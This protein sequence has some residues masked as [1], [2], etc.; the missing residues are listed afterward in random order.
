MDQ[1]LPRPKIYLRFIVIKY[2]INVQNLKY[3]T[4]FAEN[5]KEYI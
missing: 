3:E 5:S 2:E 4:M 1:F